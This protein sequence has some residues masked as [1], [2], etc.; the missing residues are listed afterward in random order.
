M[1]SKLDILLQW[2]NDNKVDWNKESLIVKEINGSFGVYALKDLK[3]DETVVKIPKECILSTKTCGIANILEE[4]NLEGGCPLALAVLYELAQKEGSPWYG[5]LQ[6]L[7]DTG[8]DLPMFWSEEEKS[9]FKGTELEDP[10]NN[11]LNDLKDDYHELVEPLLD[12]YPYIFKREGDDPYSFDKFVKASTLISSRAFEV[13]AYHE[14]ALVPFADLFNHR[15]EGEHVHFQTEFQVCEACGALEYCEHEYFDFLEGEHDDDEQG[16][17]EDEE[18]EQDDATE[19]EDDEE[20]M[21]TELPDL[22]ELEQ[23]NVDFWDKEED[24]EK[25]DTCDMV[26]D[27]DVK[28]DEELFNTYGDLPNVALL[29]KYGFCYDNNKN[30]YVSIDENSIVDCC[31]AVTAEL[32]QAKNPKVKED[33]LEALAIEHTRPRW[34]FFLENEHILCPTEGEEAEDMHD[35]YEDDC[36][37]G[38]CSGDDHDHDHEK[39]EHEH[40]E[41]GGCCGG[42][43]DEEKGRSRP[44][45][46][47]SEGLFEDKL[48]CLLHIMFISDAKFTKFAEDINNA[49]EYFEE[50][51][52]SQGQKTK[53]LVEVKRNVYQ[54]CLAL[55]EFRYMDYSEENG[56]W[57]SVEKEIEE[58]KKVPSGSRKYYAL[59]QRINEKRIIE[60][61]VDYYKKAVDEYSVLVVPSSA[62]NKKKKGP[63][64]LRK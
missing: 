8:E 14:N 60:R 13:D 5:Y 23:Q 39:D 16:E 17:W 4:A 9:W 1:S 7:P 54:A 57:K 6:S 11:D 2:F 15:G 58:R 29:S 53:A 34:E 64:R 47:N 52:G 43:E 40:D 37:D 46:I 48:M 38:C 28:K 18:D 50:L 3:K 41:D 21:D 44:Y 19:S 36:E 32:L 45:F 27:R 35:D 62:K 59:T 56:E 20:E 42:E 12:E 49:L 10:V 30:D 63:K 31:L 33:E 25:Q 51:A 26:L 22:E 61:A 55:A 24:S